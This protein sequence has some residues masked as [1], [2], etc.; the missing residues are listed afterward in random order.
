MFCGGGTLGPVTP[1]LAIIEAW[2]RKDS[3][4]E[5]VFV[6]TPHG[7]ERELMFKERIE[8]HC[9]PEAKLPRYPSLAWLLLPFRL[10]AALYAAWII[11]KK[12]KP[13]LIV[14]AGGYTSVP[15]VIIGWFL[16]IPSLVHQ[17]DVRPLLSNKLTAPFASLVTVA[18]PKL[19][20][21]F[22]KSKLVGNPVR[23]AFLHTNKVEA[24][25]HFGLNE[26]KPTV[27]AIGGGTGSLWLNQNISALTDELLF[28]ANLIHLTGKGKTVEAKTSDGYRTFELL[29]DEM[30]LAFAAADLVVCRAGMATITELAATKKAAIVI[31]LPNSPQEDNAAV[32]D[33][34]AVVLKQT[35]TTP[36]ILLKEILHL[37]KE[38]P[39]RVVMGDK[40]NKLLKTDVAEEM[41]VLGQERIAKN[42]RSGAECC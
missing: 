35:A 14:S 23:S 19:V 26:N 4:A 12:E 37:L 33:G 11:L 10:A 34:T 2:R 20:D 27:L 6:G 3:S 1:L 8:F 16:R 15:L 42:F 25:K 9:L 40:L 21:D 7:P 38:T 18:W 24:I 32:I 39:I 41:V 28:S 29:T 30:P 5:F 22:S 31:P 36:T 13:A 17:Q